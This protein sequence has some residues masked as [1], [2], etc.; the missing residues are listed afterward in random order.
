M[1]F[2]WGGSAP[3]DSPDIWIKAGDG[4]ATRR[5]TDTPD[6]ME[7]YPG[8]SPDG[9]FVAFT[10]YV[11]AHPSIFRISALGGREEMIAEGSSGRSTPELATLDTAHLVGVVIAHEV[12]HTLG[13]HHSSEGVMKEPLSADDMLAARR[14]RL[15][16]RP[17]EQERMRQGLVGDAQTRRLV[18]P[19][20]KTAVGRQRQA[21]VDCR[22]YA[23]LEDPAYTAVDGSHSR[24]VLH[25]HN[26]QPPR[27]LS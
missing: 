24:Q 27:D 18:T 20:E 4:D 12:G 9:Q 11:K 19:V 5:L 1:A 2:T 21:P 15:V 16:F 8:W 25:G 23:A 26:H 7:K 10:R 14:S 6:V 13:L 17:D 3:T 22:C